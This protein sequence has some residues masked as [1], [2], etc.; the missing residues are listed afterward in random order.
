MSTAKEKLTIPGSERSALVDAKAAGMPRAIER[1][2]ATVLLRSRFA[3]GRASA[4][5]AMSHRVPA[6]RHYLQREEFEQLHGAG[7]D[8][9]A[10]I[11]HFAAENGLH[12]LGVDL[13]ART[14][15]LAGTVEQFEAAFGTKLSRSRLGNH[16]FRTRTG[17]LYV[18]AELASIVQGVFGLD[19]RPQL[20]PHVS[21]SK[22]NGAENHQ[23]RGFSALDVARAYHFP[24]DTDGSR[25][26]IAIIELGGGLRRA[27]LKK[28]FSGLGISTAEVSAVSVNGGADASTGKTS[29]PDS[30]VMLDIE[31]IGAMAPGARIVVYFGRNTSKGFVDAIN[32]AIYDRARRPSVVSI[33][34]GAPESAWTNQAMRAVDDAFQ[35]ASLLGITVCC[36]SGDRGSSDGLNDGL[37]HVDFPASSPW[38]LACGGTRLKTSG[39]GR[40]ISETAW[41]G[42]RASGASGG[43]VSEVFDL[44]SWQAHV[45]VPVSANNGHR[46]G[47]G[48]PDVAG[49]ADPA[50]GFRTIVDGK[51]RVLGGTS[52]VAATWAALIARINQRVGTTVGFLNTVLYQP[53]SANAFRDI[54][55]GSN[56]AYDAKP[57]WDA[58][59]GLGSPVGEALARVL[60][61]PAPKRRPL[62]RHEGTKFGFL[63]EG[64]EEGE[65]EHE[66]G[67]PEEGGPPSKPSPSKPSPSKPSPSK[68][69]S[70]TPPSVTPPSPFPPSP[71]PPSPFP[72]SLFPPSPFP[73]S[74]SP[75]SPVTPGITPPGQTQPFGQGMPQAGNG[76][77]CVAI[78][79]LVSAVATTATTALASITGI[80]SAGCCCGCGGKH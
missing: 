70:V 17:P 69:P 78:V 76:C 21:V 10:K 5:E 57:G 24:M 46:R 18:P 52:A 45:G 56:G 19:D 65:G 36:A 42:S 77:C 80:V 8:D 66:E 47:R 2:E 61:T 55:E 74:P 50:S 30:E 25:Q 13:A 31:I 29:G 59:T 37:N 67:Q 64:G 38:A 49:N 72:P 68:P 9:V 3:A 7:S 54:T 60:A 71:F 33:S 58:C 41:G 14:V 6:A 28:Y 62:R 20:S 39:A 16:L 22:A 26:T 12:A 48:V 4:A 1:I 73:P 32:A 63:A 35:A 75:P 11:D 43:G 79:G 53:A 27:D 23:G 15:R 44:P 40:F 34:W 51:N